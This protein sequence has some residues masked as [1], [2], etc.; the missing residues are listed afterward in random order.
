VRTLLEYLY[1]DVKVRSP[2]EIQDLTNEK[3]E[4]ERKEL[5]QK[6]AD[7]L[8]AEIRSFIEVLLTIKNKNED[9][10][11]DESNN[12]MES[13]TS[14]MPPFAKDKNSVK[15]VSLFSNKDRG[16]NYYSNLSERQGRGTIDDQILRKKKRVV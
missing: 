2:D 7:K 3:L 10:L 12:S 6:P 5:T 15:S 14:S 13:P 11:K 1:L 9:T 4:S 8:I 16:L